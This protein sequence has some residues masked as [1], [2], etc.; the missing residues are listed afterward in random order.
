MSVLPKMDRN[1][2]IVSELGKPTQMFHRWW[3]R[4]SEAVDTFISDTRTNTLKLLGWKFTPGAIAIT[5]GSYDPVTVQTVSVVS[6]G[7][8][9]LLQGARGFTISTNTNTRTGFWRD[10]TQLAWFGIEHT[11]VNDSH[12]NT[13]TIVDPNPPVGFVTYTLKVGASSANHVEVVERFL[14]VSELNQPSATG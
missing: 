10:S 13:L 11:H 12:A 4:L 3:Q 6:S 1:I 7:N 9:I 2:S 5:T 14:S 8:P